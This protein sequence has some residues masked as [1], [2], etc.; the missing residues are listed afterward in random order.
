MHPDREWR[1]Q[2]G[3]GLHGFGGVHMDGRHDAARPVGAD[4]Q[5]RH[6][7]R[8]QPAAD[9]PPVRPGAGVPGEQ[10]LRSAQ[11]HHEARPQGA[12]AIAQPAGG[13]VVRGRG[14][15]L[16]RTELRRAPPVQFDRT[17]DASAG[18]RCGVAQGGDDGRGEA[19][20][21]PAQ[22]GQ[23]HVVV[24]VVR[25]QHG[26]DAGQGV[27]RQPRR[28]C[29]PWPSPG[30]GRAAVAEH[31]VG[32]QGEHAPAGH[33]QADQE[34]AVADEGQRDRAWRDDAGRWRVWRV[35]DVR[36]PGHALPGQRPAEHGAQTARLL[37]AGVEEVASVEVVAYWHRGTPSSGSGS[38]ASVPCRTAKNTW[39]P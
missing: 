19:F 10:H 14:D 6:A 30:D 25:Q 36:G 29:P 34:G 33:R 18:Q 12:V 31:R 8:P 32:Q 15:H 39:V 7:G 13:E 3:A 9:V 23:V 1:P 5:H 35:L 4:R 21:Q 28:P 24:V 37:L 26:V 27:Q 22:A 11:P 17:R 20:V 16:D 38:M 2:V